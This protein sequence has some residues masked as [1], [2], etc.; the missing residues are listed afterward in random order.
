MPRVDLP[1][2]ARI[3]S[4]VKLRESHC[5]HLCQQSG[6]LRLLSP[7]GVKKRA[8]AP[9]RVDD[10]EGQDDTESAME[11]LLDH[12][13]GID[14]DLLKWVLVVWWMEVGEESPRAEIF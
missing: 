13:G 12:F 3:S 4:I 10:G 8:F 9:R 2:K 14:G 7:G 11:D 1:I 6:D 5:Q